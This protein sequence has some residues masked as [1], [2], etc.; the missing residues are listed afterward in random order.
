[1]KRPLWHLELVRTTDAPFEVATRALLEPQRPWHPRPG[2]S[3]WQV[4][5]HTTDTLEL[6]QTEAPCWGVEERAIYRVEPHEGGLLLSY[7]ARFK[8]WAVLFLMGYWRLK[9]HRIWERFVEGLG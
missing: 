5:N 9:S 1:M 3:P 2:K 7:H 4:L 8:G 6:A